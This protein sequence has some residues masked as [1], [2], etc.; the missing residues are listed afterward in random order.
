MFYVK[1]ERWEEVIIFLLPG[2]FIHYWPVAV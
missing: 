2:G 1:F